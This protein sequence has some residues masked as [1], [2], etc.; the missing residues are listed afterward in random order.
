MNNLFKSKKTDTD[1]FL[2][3]VRFF[4]TLSTRR[5]NFAARK[6]AFLVCFIL[7]VG[8]GIFAQVSGKVYYDF[9]GNGSFDTQSEYN[10]IGVPNIEIRAYNPSGVQ[11]GGTQVSDAAGNY[12]FSG[13]SF[14]VRIEFTGYQSTDFPTAMGGQNFSDIQFYTTATTEADFAIN[15]PAFY[16]H[17]NDPPLVI[18]CFANQALTADGG[19]NGEEPAFVGFKFSSTG[20][21]S[22]DHIYSADHDDIGTTYG[23]AYDR[24]NSRV[25]AA[26]VAKRHSAFGPAGAYAIY[27]FDYSD[28]IVPVLQGHLDLSNVVTAVPDPRTN[29]SWQPGPQL[30][31]DPEIFD[32]IG[33]MSFGDIEVSEDG[34][35]LWVSNLSDNSV[36]SIDV[37][38]VVSTDAPAAVG[39]VT[40][41]DTGLD[42]GC[43]NGDYRVWGL[44]LYRGSLYAGVVCTGQTTA[45]TDPADARDELFA[46]VMKLDGNSFTTE[47]GPINIQE[48]RDSPGNG[49]VPFRR[50]WNAWVTDFD[51]IVW[52]TNPDDREAGYPQPIITDLEFDIDGSIILGFGDRLGFQVGNNN[53]SVDP[54]DNTLYSGEIGGDVIRVCKIDDTYFLEGT[55]GCVT[56][57]HPDAS[58]DGRGINGQEYYSGDELENSGSHKENTQGAIA[59]L[60]GSNNVISSSMNPLSNTSGG[61]VWL[62][63]TDGWKDDGYL[64]FDGSNGGATLNKA[65]GLGDVEL[66]CA[67][68]PV[69][70]GNRVWSDDDGDGIQDADESGIAGVNV[71]LTDAADNVL[72]TAVTDAEGNYIFSTAVGTSTAAFIYNLGL[73][74]AENYK[75]RIPD[76]EGGS[77]QANLSGLFITSNDADS[78]TNGDLRDSDGMKTGDTAEAAFLLG[79]AGENNHSYDFGFR[80]TQNPPPPVSCNCIDYM[81][82]NETTDGGKVHKYEINPADGSVSEILVNGNAWYPGSGTSQLPSPHGLG[83]DLNGNLYI[84]EGL[85]PNGRIRKLN[86]AGEIVPAAEF[87][88]QR[89]PTN[90]ESVGNILF[91]ND[92]YN[93]QLEFYDLCT[94]N[95][96][97]SITFENSSG[98]AGQDWGFSFNKITETFYATE[99]FGSTTGSILYRWNLSEMT[100]GNTIDEFLTV[101]PTTDIT[102]GMTCLPRFYIAGVQGD[103]DGNIYVVINAGVYASGNGKILKYDNTGALVAQTAWDMTGGDGGWHRAIGIEYSQM[104]GFLYVSTQSATDDCVSLFD[105]DL[106]YL[107]AAVPTTGT[108]SSAKGIAVSTECC[109]TDSPIVTDTLLCEAGVGQK[110]FL[111]E[112]FSCE[113]IVCAQMWEEDPANTGFTYDDCD[114]SITVTGPN[115]C[116]TFTKSG[117]NTQCGSVDITFN[118]RVAS[119]ALEV[120]QTDCTD[121]GSNNFTADYDV[122]VSWEVA[123][124]GGAETIEVTHNGAVIGTIDTATDSSPALFTTSASA[125]GTGR[126]NFTAAY[127]AEGGCSESRSLKTPTP[128]PDPVGDCTAQSGCIGGNVFEDFN[129]N[130]AD[131]PNEPGVTG[132]QALIYDCENT[133][134][135]STYS[136]GQGNWQVCGLNDTEAY[137]VEFVLPESVACW[138]QPTH[139]GT[140]NGSDV[141]F[142]TAPACTEFSVSSSADYCQENPMIVTTCFTSGTQS[143]GLS[144]VVSFPYESGVTDVSQDN[145]S[146][147]NLNMPAYTSLAL[148]TEVGP[149][150]G[151]AYRRDNETIYAAAYFKSFVGYGNATDNAAPGRIFSID[152]NSGAVNTFTELPAGNDVH[153]YADLN[154]E[155]D[156]VWDFVGK[157]GLA[158]VEVSEDGQTLWAVNLFDRKL[159]EIDIASQNFQTHDFAVPAD[160]PQHPDTPAGELDYNLRPGGLAIEKG[161]LYYTLTCTAENIGTAA[162][163]PEDYLAAYVY[164]FEN[165]IHT[166]VAEADLNYTRPSNSAGRSS[167]GTWNPWINTETFLCDNGDD[168]A[169][170]PQ[171]W[172]WDIEFD[173][174]Q[175]LILGIADRFG[176]QTGVQYS[177]ANNSCISGNFDGVNAG[178]VVIFADNGNGTWT[179]ENNGSVGNRSSAV[180]IGNNEGIGGGEFFGEDNYSP[181]HPFSLHPEIT[182]GQVG[183]VKGKGEVFMSA[184]DPGL[185][186]DND[187]VNAGGVIW[188]STQD[189]NRTRSYE[190]YE[191]GDTQTF[192]KAAGIGDTEVMCDAAPLEIGNYVW[193]DSL[194][195]GIQ[196][197]CERGID[198]LTVQLYDAAGTLVGLTATAAGGQYVFNET[199]V[200]V[201]GVNP[202]GSATSGSYTG[203]TAETDYFIVFGDGQFSGGE[204]TFG[205]NDYGITAD[206][207]AGDNDKIDSDVDPSTLTSGSLGNRPDGLPFIAMTTAETGCG[208]HKYDLGVTC[209]DCISPTANLAA[210]EGSCTG[211]T[212]NDDATLS[213]IQVTDGD[214]A[215]ASPGSTYTGPAYGDASNTD[216]SGGSGTL[217]GLMHDTEYTVRIWNGEDGCFTDETITTPAL[218]C[219]VTVYSL[220]NRV[221]NDSD[222][223]G[224]QNGTETGID[225]IELL[226][227]NADGS[228]YDS[229]PDTPGIQPLTVITGNGGYY[230]FDDLPEGDYIVEITAANFAASGTL[231][232]FSS[233]DGAAQESNPNANGDLNDNGLDTPFNGA[234]RSGVITLSGTEPTG[235]TAPGSYAAGS[236]TGTAAADEFSNL[237]VDFGFYRQRDFPDCCDA[238]CPSAPCHFI[239]SDI[240][241]GNEVT[242]DPGASDNVDSDADDG[243]LLGE[244][245]RIVAGGNLRLPVVIYNASGDDAYFRMW[246][247]WNGD[248]DFDDADEQVADEVFSAADNNGTFTIYQAV[249]V[250]TTA[251]KNQGLALRMRV[252]TDD[253][254]TTSPCGNGDCAADGETEEYLITVTCPTPLCSP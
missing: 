31:R 225:G 107:G 73:A 102:I 112:I 44:K 61:I 226:L 241:F 213:L 149:V 119:L 160:C 202:D 28:P 210:A 100:D 65:L 143:D 14:P 233:T 86:C 193:C 11:V 29:T 10:E 242:A 155:H 186:V 230:R 250:P 244:N 111:N 145:S 211:D 122:T 245:V 136:D 246:I 43:T 64:I 209:T 89:A 109:P 45:L 12:N 85:Q 62:N 103:N 21:N 123:L 247:D 114:Q 15:Y 252:S 224:T 32:L 161:V 142:V 84:G 188:L 198:G 80:Q 79:D 205:G 204:F 239:D 232:H 254:G 165:G 68:A 8:Q 235:E 171:P 87:N 227:L 125:D 214:Q 229:D 59:L 66:L 175:F 121:G 182:L 58:N 108:S 25:Y 126:Q 243:L 215:N 151:L 57:L 251:Q 82:L 194:Q 221:F 51:Q 20:E 33:K 36:Y 180:G 88:I 178:D 168:L 177:S 131:D 110:L 70:I 60:A 237:T 16:C 137:R 141:Q 35:T 63:N 40:K 157:T 150:K 37:S 190:L 23:T 223:N 116:G 67:P 22:D 187:N 104:S 134:V 92:W 94:G 253:A 212:P 208:D 42:P 140:D 139:L 118:V 17:S 106:N 34:N 120:A 144:S 96:E 218:D 9:N 90:L 220:G 117:S 101:C 191:N 130:G 71:E 55:G 231:Q 197:A 48:R 189:G 30:S 183:L 148:D 248:G 159:Y 158:D 75:V 128:C 203:L 152:V 240:Y 176:D 222:R 146:G 207:D 53:S 93:Q 3:L 124:C 179:V 164:K 13:L 98:A 105:T 95:S 154:Q 156:D 46:Y 50:Q 135:G 81:Y 167:P 6:Y 26:S 170:Y 219:A 69:E 129:C 234:V 169:F 166:K 38:S 83:M 147:G 216:V 52:S 76:A 162:G 99:A 49:D 238:A 174:E 127:T 138:A 41:Y 201:N 115:A 5:L 185:R 39:T 1:T 133:L 24:K 195:N 56:P 54:A 196:D 27:M 192:A 2:F 181:T 91:A 47:F 163:N 153:Q 19:P 184:F 74:A 236:T 97:G 7:P 132:V 77:Q 217:T 113:G 18:P 78:S 4:S 228:A 200:D 206:F 72:A 199:N 172:A 173:E 249:T